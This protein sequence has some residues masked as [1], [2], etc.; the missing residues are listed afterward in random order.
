MA[1]ANI[2]LF[3]HGGSAMAAFCVLHVDVSPIVAMKPQVPTHGLHRAQS[4]VS[5]LS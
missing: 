1:R 2:F 3:T 4:I 5:K